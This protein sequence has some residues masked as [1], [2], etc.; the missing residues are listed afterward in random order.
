MCSEIIDYQTAGNSLFASSCSS[1]QI[2]LHK[3]TYQEIQMNSPLKGSLCCQHPHHD[4]WL[5]T[6]TFLTA[7]N[8][9]IIVHCFRLQARFPYQHPTVPA[10]RPSS[11]RRSAGVS[12]AGSFTATTNG[13]VKLEAVSFPRIVYHYT[14]FTQLLST[15][16]FSCNFFSLV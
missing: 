12:A 11:C 5:L 8:V 1:L 15:L 10:A 14:L 7:Q 9:I 3:Q 6:Y 4:F 2:R 13:T 16:R